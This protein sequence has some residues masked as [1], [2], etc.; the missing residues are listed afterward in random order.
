[1]RY[2]YVVATFAND[3][4]RAYIEQIFDEMWINHFVASSL[5]NRYA[6][7]VPQDAFNAF[8]NRCN[9]EGILLNY[10]VEEVKKKSFSNSK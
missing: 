2:N 10:F 4:S 3:V 5:I 6:L 1:M 9:D 7:E 8:L